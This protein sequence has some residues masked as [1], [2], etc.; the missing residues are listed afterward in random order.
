MIVG[1][2]SR[3]ACRTVL[4][5]GI[6]SVTF[7]VP[8]YAHGTEPTKREC[9]DANVDAQS[10]RKAGKL[11]ASRAALRLCTSTSCP[12]PV[13]DDCAQRLGELD[14]VLPSIVFHAK[15]PSGT[16]VTNVRVT[17]DGE[18]LAEKLDG[19]A[20]VVDPGEHT[21]TFVEA[22]GAPII[23][24]LV[25][26]EGE[27]GRHE[28]VTLPPARGPTRPPE[29]GGPDVLRERPSAAGTGRRTTAIIV[30]GAGVVGLGV[31]GLLAG[32]AASKSSSSRT[33]CPSTANC[34][35]RRQSVADHDSAVSL[36]TGS[37]IA[38]VVGSAVVATGV[39][40]YFTAPRGMQSSANTLTV[41]PRATGDGGG[42]AV[43]GRF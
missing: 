13:R 5:A 2:R 10:L 11:V 15:G 38:V 27:R 35:D 21:F 29:D 33:N 30:G 3:A 28:Q 43:T 24:R 26:R 18:P 17:V 16:G 40:L 39:V 42:I 19:T 34:P 37:T 7:L 41:A 12:G 32:L 1:P 25:V 6:L 22:G 9:I 8:T 23:M 14:A 4:A 20:L 36:A 31:G